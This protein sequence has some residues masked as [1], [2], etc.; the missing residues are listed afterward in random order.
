MRMRMRMSECVD[1]DWLVGWLVRTP[2][3][4]LD[5]PFACPHA[6]HGASASTHRNDL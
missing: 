2:K 1:V 3:P 6:P 5:H 4:R